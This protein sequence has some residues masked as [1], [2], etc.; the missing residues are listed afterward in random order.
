MDSSAAQDV[1]A[2]FLKRNPSR[3]GGTFDFREALMPQQLKFVDDPARLKSLL[4]PRRAGKTRL[5]TAYLFQAVLNPASVAK[6]WVERGE[7][8]I[9]RY[10]APTRERAKRLM[11][12]PLIRFA[13]RFRIPINEKESEQII[14]LENGGEIRLV[15][16][17][18][19]KEAQKQRGD[20]T[21]LE[22]PDEAS[23]YGNHLESM[24]EEVIGPSTDDFMG[25]VG[26]M[27]TPGIV[28]D[29]YWFGVSGPADESKRIDGWSRHWIDSF[30]NTYLPHLKAEVLEKK[31]QKKW[32]DDNPTWLREYRGQWVNDLSALFY[33][34][35]PDRNSYGTQVSD[36]PRLQ[37]SERWE[38]A[39]GWDLGNPKNQALTLWSFTR[40][41]EELY[42]CFSQRGFDSWEDLAGCIRKLEQDFGRLTY[43]VAD[44]GGLG[45]ELIKEFGQKHGIHFEHAKKTDKF[46]FVTEF[47]DELRRGVIKTLR[48]SELSNEYVTLPKDPEDET[49][50]AEGY[51]DH[52]S[53]AALYAWRRAKHWQATPREDKPEPGTVEAMRAEADMDRKR[54]IQRLRQKQSRQ[55]WKRK[56]S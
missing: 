37:G 16:A 46:A 47:N 18:K 41:E 36:R 24:I 33:A 26:L 11:W 42:E 12:R 45:G 9:A 13:E 6:A 22:L 50:P 8:P 23:V 55:W 56:A 38:Y 14:Y 19:D 25:V 31:R 28:F 10:W 53:D 43:K 48:G 44:A 35:D 54:T 32:A 49:Q 29:G 1:I 51:P 40:H 21:V 17:D 34:W 4:A 3:S 52:C 27:G 2:A 7:P 20:A 5:C 15:G 30:D 39:L